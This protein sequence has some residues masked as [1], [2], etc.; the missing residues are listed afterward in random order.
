MDL[1]FIVDASGSIHTRRFP[2]VLEYVASVVQELTIGP[3]ATQVSLVSY[4]DTATM[5]FHLNQY[6]AMD[7]LI[8]AIK[9]VPY[10]AGKT[11]TSGGIRVMVREAER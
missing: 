11:N 3:N 5:E 4:S 1:S 2:K 7:D 8:A 6:S 10:Q 9:Q